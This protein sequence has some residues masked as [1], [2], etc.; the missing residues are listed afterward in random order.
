[1]SSISVKELSH[2]AGEV[3]KIAAGKTLDLKSQGTTTLPTGSV[4]QV[5][6][7]TAG[8]N[9]TTSTTY[10]DGG[11]T[12]TIT[13]SSTSSKILVL[14]S[15]VGAAI[16]PAAVGYQNNTN[17]GF[18]VLRDSTAI[19]TSASDSGGKYGL[20]V[21]AASTSVS[22]ANWGQIGLNILDSPSTISARTYK[23]Q[24]A[25]GT[26]GMGTSTIQQQSITLMEVSA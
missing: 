8:A 2:P 25:L 16:G 3:I 10:V 13:P 23:L 22:L 11:L 24:H 4:L 26:S 1:M 21:A 17:Q 18:Q 19:Y 12:A 5:I 9:T 14:V 7:A 6:N 15:G 20:G